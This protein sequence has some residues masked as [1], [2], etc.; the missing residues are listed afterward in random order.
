M[1]REII[2]ERAWRAGRLGAV[3]VGTASVVLAC[4]FFLRAAWFSGCAV[5]VLAPFVMLAA[6][7]GVE[8]V[9]V[10]VERSVTAR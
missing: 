9:A 2:D 7:Y 8:R 5:A 10:V 1:T 3:G 6:F 4:W